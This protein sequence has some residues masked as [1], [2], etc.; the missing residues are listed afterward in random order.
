MSHRLAATPTNPR[1]QGQTCGV[2]GGWLDLL[3]RRRGIK[4]LRSHMRDSTTPNASLQTQ[5]RSRTARKQ[6]QQRNA[7][8]LEMTN[9]ERI[10]SPATRRGS[11]TAFETKCSRFC[12]EDRNETEGQRLKK[13]TKQTHSTTPN[14]HAQPPPLSLAPMCNCDNPFS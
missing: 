10:S 13:V 5:K 11:N 2:D 9:P 7:D 6:W 14:D 4:A 3:V 8:V 1:I 12:K